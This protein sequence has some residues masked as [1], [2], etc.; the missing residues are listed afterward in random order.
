MV[1]DGAFFTNT[2]F[3]QIQGCSPSELML[4]FEPQQMHSDLRPADQALHT[5]MLDQEGPCHIYQIFTALRDGQ[6]CLA[7]DAVAYVHYQKSRNASKQ[8]IPKERYLVVVRNHTV[9]SQKGRKL[10]SR[11]FGPRILVSYTASGLSA[12]LRELHGFGKTKRY[13]LNDL[14]L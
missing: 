2:K 9:D 13:H 11:W 6:R 10:E 5:E 4:G 7:S 12:H 8:I 1:K 14:L 3:Q